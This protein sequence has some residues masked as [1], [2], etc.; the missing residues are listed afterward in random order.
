MKKINIYSKSLIVL[1]LF[2]IVTIFSCNSAFADWNEEG[3]SAVQ[4]TLWNILMD[5][6]DN[7]TAAAAVMGNVAVESNYCP[8]R[9]CGDNDVENSFNQSLKYVNRC[10]KD[11]FVYYWENNLPG[12]GLFQFST[13]THMENLWNLAE[14]QGVP[15]YDVE[16]QADYMLQH[17]KEKY[18]RSI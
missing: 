8:W 12:F 14:E 17:F 13:N 18:P 4:E 11:G 10:S 15:V 7:P 6:F 1:S 9:Y 3:A 16:L 5:E 2:F